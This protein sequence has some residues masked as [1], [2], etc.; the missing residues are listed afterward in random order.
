MAQV[1]CSLN[2]GECDQEKYENDA[3]LCG[4]EAL[5]PHIPANS[6]IRNAILFP[7]TENAPQPANR[8]ATGLAALA[9]AGAFYSRVDDDPAN[10]DAKIGREF[11]AARTHTALRMPSGGSSAG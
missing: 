10:H 9:C 1:G 2:Q 6:S 11:S 5:L 7:T 8:A 4:D 3:V